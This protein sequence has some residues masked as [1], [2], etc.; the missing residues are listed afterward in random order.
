[1]VFWFV[2][3]FITNIMGP[4]IPDIIDNFGLSKLALASFIPTSFFLAYAVLSI[5]GGLLIEK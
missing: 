1:M 4:L 3:S 2:I 5:P